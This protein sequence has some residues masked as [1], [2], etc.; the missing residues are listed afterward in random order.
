M[1]VTSTTVPKDQSWAGLA[2][3]LCSFRKWV[4]GGGPGSPVAL[5]KSHPGTNKELGRAGGSGLKDTL[6]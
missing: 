5:D 2:L 4:R 6:E 1:S 3:H